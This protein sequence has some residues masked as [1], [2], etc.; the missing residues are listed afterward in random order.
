MK[1]QERINKLFGALVL[2][3][4]AS[5]APAQS[6]S[7]GED[8]TG[9]TTTNSWY[10]INGACLTASTSAG[11]AS[12]TTAGQPP[13]CTQDSYY[14]ENLVGGYSGVAG[15]AT[16]LPDNASLAQG[17]LRFT[18]GCLAPSGGSTNCGN[19]GHN[20]NGA[21]I[22]GGSY[23]SNAG[24]QITFK[25]VTYRGDSYNG[26]GGDS[27]GADGMSFFLIDATK[28]PNIG[29]YGGSLGYSCS[30]TNGPTGVGTGGDWHGMYGAYIGLGIDEF[31]NFLNASDNTST[32]AGYVPNRIGLRG[33]GNVNWNYLSTLSQYQNSNYS[34][35][36]TNCA[37]TTGATNQMCAVK[38]TCQNGYLS[39]YNGNNINTGF[40]P[41]TTS[42]PD[43]AMISGA[44]VTLPSTVVIGNEYAKGGYAR[45][46]SGTNV[47]QYKLTLTSAGL[48]SLSYNVN[49]GAWT[50]VLNNQSITAS[51]G[52]IPTNIRFGFAG[53]TGGG[54][55]IHEV[56]CFKAASLDASGSSAGSN[57]QQSSKITGTTQ[58]YFAYYNPNDWTG[59]LT[60]NTLSANATTGVVTIA[61]VANWDASCVLTG[62]ACSATGGT[63]TVEGPTARTIL[64]WSSPTSTAT[65]GLG[66]P[67]EWT[68][69]ISTAEQGTLEAGDPLAA[70]GSSDPQGL[71]RVN[72]LRGDRTCEVNTVTT[73]V[74][75][76]AGGSVFRQ[77]DGVLGDIV[78]S[79]PVQVG[80]P[81]SPYAVTW[82]DKLI[83][84]DPTPENTGQSYATFFSA[85][86]TRENVVYVGANDG[87]LHGFEAGAYDSTNT[88]QSATNDG[89][90]LLAYMPAAVVNTIH[91]ST[92]PQLD[93]SSPYYGHNFYVDATPGFGDLY[94]SGAW[95]TWLVGGLGVGGNAIYAL[96]VTNPLD[97]TNTVNFSETHASTTVIGEWSAANIVCANVA[98]CASNLGNTFGTPVVR[99]LHNGNWAVIFGNGFS[100]TTGDAG[101]YVAVIS[102]SGTLSSFYYLST[103]TGVTTG[104]CTSNCNGIAY[105]TP[106][107]LDG[108]H[109]TDY[110]Y[111]GDLR[112]NIWR[113]D[114]TSATPSSW[115]AG[116]TP[117]F[118][119][120]NTVGTTTT[121][122][123]ITSALLVALNTGTQGTQVI[124]S[125]GTGRQI[126]FTNTT[127]ASYATGTQSLYAV[128]DW[129]FSSWN[130]KSS[131]QY[132]SLTATA[133][134]AIVSTGST[135]PTGNLA[136]QTLSAGTGGTITISPTTVC[137]AG[138]TTCTGTN[139]SFGWYAPLIGTQEQIIFNP[140]LVGS[141]FVVNSVIPANNLVLA[142]TLSLNTGYTYAFQLA[143]GGV[144]STTVSGV[145]QNFFVNAGN[146]NA[147]GLLTNATGTSIVVSTTPSGTTSTAGN[148]TYSS[149]S[150]VSG[151]AVPNSVPFPSVSSCGSGPNSLVYQNS[152]GAGGSTQIAVG[153]PLSGQ[154][155]TW[156][157]RR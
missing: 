95:H 101:I 145:A 58:A 65:T 90:E 99:R 110:V 96:D 104:S 116:A 121:A 114:L 60:A 54:S 44:A 82:K 11:S 81:S 42:V 25:T 111:A 47:L 86:L 124:V 146:P 55:N 75:A 103:G 149:S 112:G 7:V 12:A 64:T 10:A 150:T 62:G 49:G 63:N 135:I 130:S 40:H 27:D 134:S 8:F 136:K 123:P 48:L 129:N 21:I 73:L 106:V 22:S 9:A 13:G 88:Y 127:S 20:Q 23:A 19:G 97:P 39:D 107:D 1:M 76:L 83:G 29:S 35:T 105:V 91:N 67:F 77:R 143:T 52:T 87:M 61:S 155:Q 43:Y 140:E 89:K 15:S 98:S 24:L 71:A 4:F 119:A 17:A 33:Y 28:T 133:F 18:N 144:S 92:V 72:F 137:W 156:F 36:V 3:A 122:Q 80:Q 38:Y 153:C 70:L 46:S 37:G 94:Y 78:D 16:T 141:T 59:R 31:G 142:C 132:A 147:V 68:S 34:T 74:C 138:T 113:F 85:E 79:S 154:R 14:T 66:V 41:V 2:L 30:N 128:W 118:T 53:S 84:T 148:L 117:L 139:S 108:D 45:N 51:N 152:A 6:V 32:G 131:V 102:T 50:G 120:S 126:E 157:Q 125:F 100:S 93:Y 69:G 26:S 57:L 151:A 56:L 115:A 5:V 109:I